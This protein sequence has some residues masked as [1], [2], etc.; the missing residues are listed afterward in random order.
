MEK[1]RRETL[2]ISPAAGLLRLGRDVVMLLAT[3]LSASEHQ[4]LLVAN[5]A[6]CGYLLSEYSWTPALEIPNAPLF[7][8]GRTTK[9]MLNARTVSLNVSYLKPRSLKGIPTSLSLP[10][11]ERALHYNREAACEMQARILA[12]PR[13]RRLRLS[14]KSDFTDDEEDCRVTFHYLGVDYRNP[15]PNPTQDRELI[16]RG[17]PF[18]HAAIPWT[19]LSVQGRRNLCCD[20]DPLQW[21]PSLKQ[22]RLGPYLDFQPPRFPL[23]KDLTRLTLD[24]KDWETYPHFTGGGQLQHLTATASTTALFFRFGNLEM[25]RMLR[26]NSSTLQTLSLTARL[27]TAGFATTNPDFSTSQLLEKIFKAVSK[28]TKAIDFTLSLTFD[29]GTDL[30]LTALCCSKAHVSWRLVPGPRSWSIRLD[31]GS[32]S[33]PRTWASSPSPTAPGSGQAA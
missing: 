30:L 31:C 10:F 18:E 21:P 12:S 11:V 3:F 23:P 17:V 8:W 32:G 33:I 13:F 26:A 29:Q 2:V 27:E 28:H 16:L 4:R 19:S 5:S 6:I 9:P 24:M 1:K 20:E 22:L 14:T 25:A 15:D 7:V